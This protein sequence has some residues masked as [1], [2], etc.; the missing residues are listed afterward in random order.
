RGPDPL[1]VGPRL[2]KHLVRHVD[3]DHSA[4]GPDLLGGEEAIDTRAAA[5]IDHDLARTHGGERLRVAAAKPE[6]GALRQGSELR[7]G[8]AHITGRL[9]R[10]AGRAAS[11]ATLGDAAVPVAYEGL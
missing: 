5:E 10:G 9:L 4:A 3:P 2:G 6:I 8:I 11:R 1:G 7:L